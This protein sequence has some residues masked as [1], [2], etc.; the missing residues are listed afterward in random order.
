MTTSQQKAKTSKLV[1]G[2]ICLV[3]FVA[4]VILCAVY[5]ALGKNLQTINLRE[6]AVVTQQNG[7]YSVALDY[8]K[9]VKNEH[10]PSADISQS[11]YFDESRFPELDLLKSIVFSVEKTPDGM[12]NIK[13]LVVSDTM[14]SEQMVDVL[15]KA[16]LELSNTEWT[17]TKQAMDTASSQTQNYPRSLDASKF[18]LIVYDEGT[19]EYKATMDTASLLLACGFENLPQTDA[20]VETI[21]SLG[22]VAE[23]TENGYIIK[24]SSTKEDIAD[25]LLV[26]R[27]ELYNTQWTMT[28]S[29]VEQ[30]ASA[31]PGSP[32]PTPETTDPDYP[33]TIDIK[34]YVLITLDARTGEYSASVDT[35][36]LILACG[37]GSLA[38][39]DERIETIKSLGFIATR[40]EGS[41][42]IKLSSAM[43]DI[44]QRLETAQI[45]FSNT[46]FTMTISELQQALAFT[47]TTPTP[48]TSAPTNSPSATPT[49][50]PQ[51]DT[52]TE[53]CITSLYGY[54]QTAVR[55][56]IRTAKEKYYSSAYKDSEVVYNYF[57][58]RKTET[59]E[60]ANCF[61]LVLE[62]S[63]SGGT[64]Y[65]VAD[66]YNLKADT[67]PK[68]SEVVTHTYTTKSASRGTND[69]NSSL[70]NVYTL[71]GGSMVFSENNGKNPFNSDGL[72]FDNS[73]DG[74]I[75]TAQLWNIPATSSRSLLSLLGYAR[76]EIFARCGHEF[77]ET[78][79]YYS[80]YKQFSWYKPTGSVSFNDVGNKCTKGC[81]NIEQIK[82]L[83]SLIKKG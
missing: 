64:E 38:D 76:N 9:L 1:A 33:R 71:D 79:A 47:P 31:A 16:G 8:G 6:Y 25:R 80:H 58:V 14:N 59:A 63:T 29:E 4:A 2:I 41:Y 24:L 61:R 5:F 74:T 20:R 50:A 12:Y 15:H 34:Q 17:W 54:D 60:Y 69:F 72:V 42:E 21:E 56:A 30:A 23:K 10:L 73:L 81:A 66:V 46:V 53:G 27:I 39:S 7:E 22:F 62:I 36:R 19:G 44:T 35:Q 78:S 28:Q 67:E 75:T 43:A 49:A 48:Q 40:G 77:K 11:G 45:E 52:D 13:T 3:I 57:I 26:A 32:S 82:V 51:I 70:Y 65:M 37:F 83:E 18:L 55:Q 68:S